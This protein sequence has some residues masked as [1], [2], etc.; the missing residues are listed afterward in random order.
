MRK[1]GLI[2]KPLSHTFSPRY[3][4]EKFKN[5]NIADAEYKAY[6]IDSP[7]LI[8]DLFDKDILGLNVTIPFKETVIPYLDDLDETALSIMA[9]NTIKNIDGNLI[10]YNTDLYGFEKSID[11]DY[12]NIG[13]KKALVL[14]TGGA[15]K[16]VKFVLNSHDFEVIFVSRSGSGMV[17]DNL[18]K[19]IIQSTS[20][21]VN[22][23]PLGMAPNVGLCPSI[24]YEFLTNKHLVYDLIYNPEKTLFLRNASAQNA[25]I[26]NGLTMLKLQ[27]ERSWEIWNE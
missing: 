17:Y 9:V 19:S 8:L 20:I 2:G 1:Y 18:T 26:Q 13:L 3:F 14:G 16:A 4:A 24:P 23:T 25:I 21:I 12:F 22:T 5:Q 6:E 27:A 10:G 7:E 15:A 11:P